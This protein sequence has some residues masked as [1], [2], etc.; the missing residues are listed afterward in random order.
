MFRFG[1]RAWCWRKRAWHSAIVKVAKG[2]TII[3]VVLVTCKNKKLA[4]SKAY[5]IPPAMRSCWNIGI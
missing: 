1:K 2:N 5:S 3:M 4:A